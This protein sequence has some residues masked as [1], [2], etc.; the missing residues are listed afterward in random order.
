MTQQLERASCLT[1]EPLLQ[2]RVEPGEA[3]HPGQDVSSKR[4][5][6]GGGTHGSALDDVVIQQGLCL[7]QGASSQDIGACK[8]SPSWLRQQSERSLGCASL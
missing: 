8:C 2:D 6:K 3:C 7:V 5:G 4:L 1:C